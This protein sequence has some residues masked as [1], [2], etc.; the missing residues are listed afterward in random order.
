MLSK[1]KVEAL[2]K[3]VHIISFNLVHIFIYIQGDA[4]SFSIGLSASDVSPET[5]YDNVDALKYF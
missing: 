1:N 3:W 4:L 5:V 2:R